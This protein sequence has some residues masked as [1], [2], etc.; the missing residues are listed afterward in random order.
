[1]FNNVIIE[2][3]NKQR[4]TFHSKYF[5]N[6]TQQPSK[7]IKLKTNAITVKNSKKMF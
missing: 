3:V 6:D 5:M 1:M 4:K 2:P 7:A